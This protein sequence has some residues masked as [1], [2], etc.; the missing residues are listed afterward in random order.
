M[1][2]QCKNGVLH[3]NYCV[4]EINFLKMGLERMFLKEASVLV[5][6]SEI[7][8]VEACVLS[9]GAKTVSTSEYGS[10]ESYHPKKFTM[11]PNILENNMLTKMS[12]LMQ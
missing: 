8:W 12:F 1:I 6:G 7:P 5:V 3:G 4:D 2:E 11:T 10:T 9:V